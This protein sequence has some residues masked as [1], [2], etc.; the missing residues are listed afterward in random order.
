[1]KDFL[2]SAGRS[3]R[4]TKTRDTNR[5][6]ILD[7]YPSILVAAGFVILATTACSFD[8]SELQAPPGPGS[9]D[10]AVDRAG[11]HP[12]SMDGRTDAGGAT[13]KDAEREA[14]DSVPDLASILDVPLMEP[15]LG[16]DV[17]ALIRDAGTE[18]AQDARLPMPDMLSD[19]RIADSP[20]GTAT[21]TVTAS[22]TATMTSLGPGSSPAT[23]TAT[24]TN[25]NTMTTTH[26]VTGSKTGTGTCHWL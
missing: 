22:C 17:P 24:G 26:T 9:M 8:A 1:M 2:Q 23:S 20:S 25:T 7:T 10:S 12:T 5:H 21:S 11:D 4:A 13:N 18:V 15:D 16:A 6:V 19:A 3:T 14:L